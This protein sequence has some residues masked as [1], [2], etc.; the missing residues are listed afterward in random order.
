MSSVLTRETV[1]N[2]QPQP[3]PSSEPTGSSMVE[4]LRE[5]V[6]KHC[7]SF[8]VWP[9]W[10][11]GGGRARRNGYILTLCGVNEDQNC[12]RGHHVPGCLHCYHTYDELRRI[13]EWITQKDQQGCRCEIAPFD[14]AWHI[15]PRQRWSR[16]EILVMIKILHRR[17]VDAPVDDNQQACLDELR[18]K[19]KELGVHEGL[20]KALAVAAH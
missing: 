20:W 18:S 5:I 10:S 17:D 13:A 16:N 12:S 15:A 8:E 19:L 14:R 7:A 6:Q 11:G 2:S 9:E 4:E 3:P 1:V